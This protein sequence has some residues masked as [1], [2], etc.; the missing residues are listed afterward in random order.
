MQ[1][2]QIEKLIV[3]LDAEEVINI[4]SNTCNIGL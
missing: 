2:F 3:K 1:E 4:I